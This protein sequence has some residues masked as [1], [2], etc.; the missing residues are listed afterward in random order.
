M[1]A[2][3]PATIP[4][5]L[6]ARLLTRTLPIPRVVL[7]APQTDAATKPVITIKLAA[8]IN[9]KTIFPAVQIITRQPVGMVAATL[10][11]TAIEEKYTNREQALTLQDQ[12]AVTPLLKP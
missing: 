6:T 8:T 3:M 12:D 4:A 5:T 10:A 7:T 2:S 11:I 1:A 9:A